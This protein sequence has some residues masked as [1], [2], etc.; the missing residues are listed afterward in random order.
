MPRPWFRRRFIRFNQQIL[1]PK[2]LQ[3]AGCGE[4]GYS[5]IKHVGRRSGKEYTTPV[6]SKSLSDGFVI[7]LPYGANVEWCRNVLAAGSCTLI[8][9]NQEYK[10]ERPELIGQAGAL[11]GFPAV[12]RVLSRL[13]E[14][15]TK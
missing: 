6:V 14:T 11:K 1:N 7:P 3:V 5:Y 2:T 4:S 10:M 8:W 9:N 15:R 13:E 12:T